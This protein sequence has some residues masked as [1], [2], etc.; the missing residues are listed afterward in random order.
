MSA[1]SKAL[2]IAAP[3]SGSGKTVLTLA[4]LRALKNKGISINSAKAGPDYIDPAFHAVASGMPS[5]N[6]DPW[7]MAPQRLQDLAN[8][9]TSDYL[10]IE[11]MMGLFDG[12]ADGTGSAADLG[13]ILKAPILLVVDAS[14]QSHSVAALCSGFINHRKDLDVIGV[15]LNKV[16]SAR[17]E[18]IL[19]DAL[20]QSD[21]AVFGVV[22][23]DK[24]LDLPERHLGLV[25]A[26]E[27]QDIEAFID[28]ATEI[29]EQ[30]C[31]LDRLINSFKPIQ[32]GHSDQNVPPIGQHIA[33]AK[34][35]AFTFIYPHL[36]AD[37]KKQG[38]EISF[39]SPLN[40]EKPDENAD[41]VFLPGGYPE[42][43]LETLSNADNFRLAMQLAQ[44]NG[45]L[46]YG[47]CG[48]YMVLGKGI[49][50]QDGKAHQMLELLQLE[51]SFEKKKLHLGYRRLTSK[52]DFKMGSELKG[53]EFH[54]TS[55]ISEA[56]ESL[57]EAQDALGTELGS[58]GLRNKNVMGS[59]I[60]I[61]E[62]VQ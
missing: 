51:T 13:S 39:F 6:L 24:A 17:H 12:A 34:D 23:R 60:H 19:R 16:G 35:A 54:Y 10:L 48:G 55:A 27:I 25:Q 32:D 44:K 22:M 1:T 11:A 42:L 21:I 29:I 56:G 46:I 5:V 53:H 58:V 47:E 20:E 41:A 45:K 30:S 26:G 37:W 28:N 15:L 52:T 2:M 43:H 14:K 9:Q 36:L 50:G 7:A 8:N 49:V 31:D 18:T 61:I 4:L 38:A 40:D 3:S 62:R 33:I 59:Y 57:F